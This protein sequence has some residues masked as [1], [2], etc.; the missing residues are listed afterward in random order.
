MNSLTAS[1]AR[2]ILELIRRN[3]QG[4]ILIHTSPDGDAIASAI[5]LYRVIKKITGYSY[6]LFCPRPIPTRYRFL[7]RSSRFRTRPKKVPFSIVL[8]TASLSRLPGW[9]PSGLI[10]NIDHHDSNPGFGVI[11]IVEPKFSST[12]EILMAL[13]K[14]WRIGIDP[15]TASILYAGIFAETGGFIFRNTKAETL[16]NAGHLVAAGAPPAEV[17]ERILNQT[18]NRLRLLSLALAT[19]KVVN[20]ISIISVSRAMFRK[21][22]T[23]IDE[24]EGFVEI[25]LQI[26]EVRISILLKELEDGRTK[27]SLRS[28]GRVN[29]N[30]IA[31]RFGGG[32]HRNAAGFVSDFSLS[33][34]RRDLL[35]MIQ[36]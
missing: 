17:G 14:R 3:D 19:L 7:T 22:R 29:V 4:Q 33:R 18:P 11:N 26:P 35:Q 15:T 21:T 34:T 23:T 27:V 31:Q 36:G 24:T 13:F 20:G 30:R 2:R 6:H 28:K 1:K 10:I 8:D 5:G 25:P 32:G 16:I 9:K 12:V